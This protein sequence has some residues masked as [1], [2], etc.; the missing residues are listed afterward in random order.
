MVVAAFV[1]VEAPGAERIKVRSGHGA[2]RIETPDLVPDATGRVT[3][4]LLGLRPGKRTE[5]VV[6]AS[7]GSQTLQSQ[8]LPFEADALPAD[9]ELPPLHTSLD[10]GTAKGFVLAALRTDKGKVAAVF[11][12]RGRVMWYRPTGGVALPGPFLRL[13]NGNF[14]LFN[15]R[16]RVYEE[17]NLAGWVV[18]RWALDAP[19]SDEGADGHEFLPLPNDRA[20]VIGWQTHAAD[21]RARFPNGV[22]TAKRR[23]NTIVELHPEGTSRVIWSTHPGIGL[24][25][26]RPLPDFEINPASF[27]V[28]HVNSIDVSPDGQLLVVTCRELG[29]VVA[30]DRASGKLRWRLGGLRGDLEIIGDSLDGFS[31]PHDARLLRDG[32]LRVF[33]N[34]NLHKPPVSRVVVYE[35]DETKRTARLVW[36]YRH[37]PPIYTPIGGSARETSPGR[38]VVDFTNDG[39][40]T[41]IDHEGRT[42]WEAKLP[43]TRPYRVEWVPELYP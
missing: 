37:V 1:D 15:A 39:T 31:A 29:Q 38:M 14:V 7:A 3:A 5:L 16:P 20:L 36:E 23:D 30:V 2:D 12:R 40:I 19:A 33:D 6:E 27:E 32:R 13:A 24:D 17:V 18:R 22:A 35:L 9:L 10:D 11:D 21:T 26:L 8:P 4:L 34:G 25:E 42:H 28:A 43:N 41:E